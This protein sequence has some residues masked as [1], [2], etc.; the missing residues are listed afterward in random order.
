ME[1][2]I[3]QMQNTASNF[4]NKKEGKT[5]IIF[6]ILI[7]A[8]LVWVGVKILPWI[9]L[10]MQN[11]ITAGLLFLAIFI[12]IYVIFSQRVRTLAWFAFRQSMRALTGAFVKINPIAIMKDYIV[13]LQRHQ[14]NMT[15]QI[16]TVNGQIK[17]VEQKINKYKSDTETEMKKIKVAQEQGKELLAKSS[18]RSVGRFTESAKTL[19]ALLTKMKKL[20]GVLIKMEEVADFMIKDLTEEVAVKEDEYKLIKASH[21]ALSSAMSAINGD[22][23]KRAVFEQTLE[24]LQEDMANKVGSMERFMQMSQTFIESVD[25]DNGVFENQALEML[26]QYEKDGFE[27][28]YSSVTG[29]APRK[30][31]SALNMTMKKSVEPDKKDAN[32]VKNDWDNIL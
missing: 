19:M 4:F 2:S 17:L 10:A 30:N 29:Q 15:E 26:E 8:G 14:A 28:M 27:S 13:S 7:G 12:L 11:I 32:G 20:Y 21:K 9:I 16:T 5:G 22:P 31:S 3:S 6:L 24:Y 25:V 1:N 18:E 23:D